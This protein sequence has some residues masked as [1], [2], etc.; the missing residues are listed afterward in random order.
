MTVAGSRW[1]C[2]AAVAIPSPGFHRDAV[3]PVDGERASFLR[4]MRSSLSL[5]LALAAV[6]FVSPL[7]ANLVISEVLYN[8]VGNNTAGEWIEIYNNGDS[9]LSLDG[10]KIGD[11]ETKGGTGAGEAMF[12]FPLGLSIGP[13]EVQIIAVDS[14]VF[15]ANY[16]F[17]PTYELAGSGTDATVPDLTV[18]SLWD[19][20][21]T[22]INMSNSND[23]AVLLGPDDSILDAVSW[24][25]T[26]A[27][28][29]GLNADAEG[30]GQS[31]YRINPNVD[32]DTAS[33]WAL[34]ALSSPGVVAVTPVP[35]P[36][37][38]SLVLVGGACLALRR[39]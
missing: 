12:A 17:K 30:D 1:G 28:S 2:P 27:F 15:L 23:Q 14:S 25:G 7:R 21:G 32:T 4:T 38:L 8:E 19:G 18:Y 22:V 34:G 6:S 31:Y 9:A 20:D 29:P 26:F 10:Y 5:P 36:M 24:G 37:T 33:D 39:R 16:G 35:E 11:E 3:V 13:G